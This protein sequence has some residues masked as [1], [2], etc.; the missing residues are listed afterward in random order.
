MRDEIEGDG[1]NDVERPVLAIAFGIARAGTLPLAGHATTI[2]AEL[3]RPRFSGSR[4]DVFGGYVMGQILL[5]DRRENGNLDL[6]LRYDFVSLG[7]DAIAGRA[8]QNAVRTGFNY[9]LPLTG[10]L[11]SLHVEYARNS[12]S[13]P[14]TIVTQANPAD[15][16]RIG[17]RVNLQRYTRH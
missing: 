10:K 12:V 6:F 16:F 4:S 13:G 7:Q 11:A 9:N 14:A 3:I 2:E 5:F 8:R 15:E 1:R 17:L